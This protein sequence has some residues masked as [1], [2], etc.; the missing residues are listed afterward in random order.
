MARQATQKEAADARKK[1]KAKVAWQKYEKE[2]EIAQRVKARENKSNVESELESE[3]P[4]KV[5]DMIFF[6]E[7]ESREVIVTSAERRDPMAMFA[8]DER[9]TESRA[10]VPVLRKRAASA[11]AVGEWEAKRKRSSRP[12]VALPVSSSPAADTAEQA[13]R[14]EEQTGANAGLVAGGGLACRGC[15]RA[16]RAV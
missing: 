15:R 11:D 4:T 9:E 13:G 7:E 5:A 12:S 1:K 16:V 6:E 3:V 2:K 10:M 14:S 8:G